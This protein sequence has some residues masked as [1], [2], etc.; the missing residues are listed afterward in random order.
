MPSLC[1]AGGHSCWTRIVEPKREPEPAAPYS[2]RELPTALDFLNAIWE[3]AFGRPLLRLRSVEKTAAL[4]LACATHEEFRARL[5]DLNELVKLI[6]IPDDILDAD[7]RQIDKQQTFKRMTA[8]LE[9]RV[10]DQAE[11]E[12]ISDA[13][14]DLRAMNT[15]RNKLAH[16]GAELVEALSR[17]RI[18]CPIRDY[19]KA[20]DTVRAR[21]AE[22]LTTIRSALQ[23]A[24]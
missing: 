7:G 3:R 24:P 9:L 16:G 23:G 18:D 20:W 10:T 6:D 13:M 14:G 22:A 4:S 11:R 12:R 15:V 21:T 5:D 2:P 17:L 19:S 8:C 1:L